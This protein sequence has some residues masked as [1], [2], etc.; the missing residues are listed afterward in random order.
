MSTR[1]S[2]A[3][4]RAAAFYDYPGAKNVERRGELLTIL[5]SVFWG[6][7][8]VAIKLGLSYS[9]VYWFLLER[10]IAASL[11]GLAMLFVW[12]GIDSSYYRRSDSWIL[13][14]L[15]AAGFILQ[16][17]ALTL[18]SPGRTALLVNL[19]VVVVA[20]LSGY[21]LQEKIGGSKL[22]ALLT[23]SL[24]LFLVTAHGDLGHPGG[25]QSVGDVLAFL[26]GLVWSFYIIKVRQLVTRSVISTS[27]LTVATLVS[28]TLALSV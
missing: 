25:G 3:A 5:S 2:V 14:V 26:A 16:Y 27:Q 19:N 9:G 1:C 8:F 13:G 17:L 28:T 12:R 11:V 23:G 15:N 22:L 24:G 21:F 6:S 18:T 7:S 20:L 4:P 10:F